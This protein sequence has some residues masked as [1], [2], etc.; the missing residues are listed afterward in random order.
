MQNTLAL[1]KK[2]MSTFS[3]MLRVNEALPLDKNLE[4]PPID[5]NAEL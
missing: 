3:V 2:Q 4:A 1:S 5:G